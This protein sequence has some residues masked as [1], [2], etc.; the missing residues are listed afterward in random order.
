MRSIRS[1]FWPPRFNSANSFAK[2]LTVFVLLVTAAPDSGAA[3]TSRISRASKVCSGTSTHDSSIY[4]TL[5]TR[6][7]VRVTQKSTVTVPATHQAYL[8]GLWPDCVLTGKSTP[9]QQHEQAYDNV[10]YCNIL[11]KHSCLNGYN[12]KVTF[13]F[14]LVTPV[15]AQVLPLREPKPITKRSPN[16]S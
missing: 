14:P 12:T 13:S 2:I 5:P 15:T 8:S 9:T 1:V 11:Q 6:C 10:F 7:K 4:S 16:L 3:A